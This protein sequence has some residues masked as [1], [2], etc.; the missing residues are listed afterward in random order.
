DD[1]SFLALASGSST[2]VDA[3]IVLPAIG[4]GVSYLELRATS[5]RDP[6]ARR[7]R[8]AMAPTTDATV[9]R[10]TS[11][12]TA[13][14]IFFGPAGNPRALPGGD[15]SSDDETSITIG[16]ADDTVIFQNDVENAALGVDSVEVVVA[17]A[18]SLPIG[19]SVACTDT[20]GTPLAT[21]SRPGGFVVGGV[22]AGQTMPVRIVLSSPGTPLRISLGANTSLS[23]FAQSTLDTT[24]VNQTVDRIVLPAVP[25]PRTMLGLEQ[26]F[27]QATA[28]MG[29]VVTMMVTVTNLTDSIAVDNVRVF[30]APAATLD[31]LSGQ[32]VTLS[33]T[34]LTWDA[35]TLAPGASRSTAVKFAVN[36]REAQ[37]WARVTGNADG[38]AASGDAVSAGPVVAAIRIDN[39]EWD[40][41]GFVLGDVFIDDDGD[42]DRDPGERGVPNVSLY[43]ESGEHV[44]TDSLGVFSIAHVFEGYRVVRLDEGSLPDGVGFEEALGPVKDG[45]QPFRRENE[46]LVHLIAPGHVRVAFGLRELPPPTIEQSQRVV[47]QRQ[48]TVTPRARMHEELVLPSSYFAFGKATLLEGA[49]DDLAPVAAFLADHAGWQLLVEGHTDNVPIHTARFPSN[50]ELSV[51]RAESVRDVLASLGV[52]PNR[53]LVLGAGDM[54]PMASNTT[55]DGRTL[56]RRVEVSF[57][58]PGH[59]NASSAQKVAAAVRDVSELPDSARATVA[60][61]LSTTA[62]RAQRGTLRIEVPAQLVG[63]R[64]TVAMGDS[65]LG[66]EDGAYVFDGFARGH[67]IDCR[68]T[69]T[70]ALADTQ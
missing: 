27:R 6:G 70:V 17:S 53:V 56:N 63:V 12:V 16:A 31:F 64:L 68:M 14:S 24:V 28:A 46:R 65:L 43:L 30:E 5:A 42:G 41:E 29:D 44:V 33:G 51:A 1:P 62:E 37:G 55:V 57:I 22:A 35:G 36:S 52:D 47:C 50:F 40:I 26:T 11:A 19:V 61:S 66:R 32:D 10:V 9:V 25:D 3:A 38:D 18:M 58:P 39:E 49:R 8:I 15:G 7:V 21:S 69:F 54:R 23:V 13:A 60:W 4:T 2:P 67:A 48:V 59:E 45:P 20:S 34:S